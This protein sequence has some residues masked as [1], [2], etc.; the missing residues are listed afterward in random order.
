MA[1]KKK[2]TKVEYKYPKEAKLHGQPMIKSGSARASVP[3]PKPENKMQF[4][5]KNL[6]YKTVPP[7]INIHLKG[8]EKRFPPGAMAPNKKKYDK[9]GKYIKNQQVAT[10]KK[11]ESKDQPPKIDIQNSIKDS[12]S[13]HPRNNSAS[14]QK[15]K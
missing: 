3:S 4:D 1:K 8:D 2:E 10:P 9:N 5:Y 14:K 11:K 15:A 6:E 12:S 13:S 7:T